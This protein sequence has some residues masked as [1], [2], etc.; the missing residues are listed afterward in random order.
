MPTIALRFPG[1]RY[2]ATPWGK[3]VNE[4]DVEWPPSPWRILRALLATGFTKLGWE[5]VPE[6]AESLVARLAEEHPSYWLPSG[7]IA[8]SRHYMPTASKTTKVIDAFLRLDADDELLIHYPVELEPGETDL[9]ERLVSNLGYF[10]RAES[11]VDGRLI[12]GIEPDE[13][14]SRPVVP[15]LADLPDRGTEQVAVLAPVPPHEYTIWREAALERAVAEFE[16]ERGKRPTARDRQRIEAPY[17]ED[18][19]ACLLV[20]TA[21]L[22]RQ[23]WS[24]PPGS[25]R[26]LYTR[27][28]GT[29]ET[30]PPVSTARRRSVRPVQAALLALAS[31][32]PRGDVLPLFTRSLPQAELLHQSL[33]SLLG[34]RA[35]GCAVLTGRDPVTGEPLTGR[36]DHAHY[37]PLDLDEDGR[38]DHVLIHARM[39][40]DDLAQSAIQRLRRTWTKGDDRDLVVTCAGLGDLDAFATQLRLR[41]GRPVPAL[42]TSRVWASLTPFVPPRF[43][44]PRGHLLEDQVRAE[45]ES[46]GLPQPRSVEVMS[47]DELVERRLLR[48]VR[49]RREGRPQPPMPRAYGIRLVFDEPVTG[50]IALGYASHYGLGV[51][52]VEES[53]ERTML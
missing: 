22:Q 16:I 53:R 7:T 30:P 18:L 5:V 2:H 10:G 52:G 38:L 31:D 29:V 34:E 27:P 32:T 40:L 23:G 12:E 14:W 6:A 25:R 45:L 13:R 42:G 44:R 39:G 9:L 46:R 50:P 49:T 17:P 1:G 24:Q 47:R 15:G 51:F 4:G 11:W 20:E 37:L 41:S 35:P 28:T 43:I 8:H 26:V 36:H 48:F 19:V 21:D 3:H 33:V